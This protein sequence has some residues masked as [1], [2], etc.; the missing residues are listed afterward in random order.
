MSLLPMAGSLAQAG[1]SPRRSMERR[2]PPPA[3]WTMATFRLEAVVDF[4][5]ALDGVFEFLGR[6]VG[7]PLDL[8]FGQESEEALSLV[9]PFSK[10]GAQP[11][12]TCS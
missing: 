9:D 6:S 12:A 11:F 2:R 1:I 7:A 8:P 5:V 10:K 3:A 4:D